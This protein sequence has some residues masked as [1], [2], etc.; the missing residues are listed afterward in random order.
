MPYSTSVWVTE[1]AL[2]TSKLGLFCLVNHEFCKFSFPFCPSLVIYNFAVRVNGSAF[3]VNKFKGSGTGHSLNLGHAFKFYCQVTV[4]SFA[5]T[6]DHLNETTGKKC[7]AKQYFNCAPLS[8]CFVSHLM[9]DPTII[10]GLNN[11]FLQNIIK[12]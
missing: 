4:L 5:S 10:E 1:Y 6:D 8:N 3:S 12:R 2:A 11:L 7:G 9:L